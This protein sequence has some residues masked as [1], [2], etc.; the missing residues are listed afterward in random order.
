VVI[1][2]RG[3][4]FKAVVVVARTLSEEKG[5]GTRKGDGNSWRR[6]SVKC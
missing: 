5:C 6:A 1:A 2:G 4:F 3:F